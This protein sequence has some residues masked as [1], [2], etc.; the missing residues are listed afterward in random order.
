M[1]ALNVKCV[2]TIKYHANKISALRHTLT[3]S[4]ALEFFN[5]I[6][7]FFVFYVQM[8]NGSHR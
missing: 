6:A 5:K 2:K 8:M 4:Y 7:R 3:Q 1:A